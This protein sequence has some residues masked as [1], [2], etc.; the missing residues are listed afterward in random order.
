MPARPARLL[1]S[2]PALLTF[3]VLAVLPLQAQPAARTADEK[4]SDLVQLTKGHPA[5]AKSRTEVA[6]AKQA[7][8][9]HLQVLA[10]EAAKF[11]RDNPTH[12]Q[13]A[14][15]RRWEAKSRLTIA[16][17]D[18]GPPSAAVNALASEVRR[19][20][21]LPEAKRYEVAFLAEMAGEGGRGS[22]DRPA[23]FAAREQSARTLIAEFPGQS[24]GYG[25]LL[26]VAGRRPGAPAA[27][28]ARELT[29]STAPADIK[30][31]AQDLL[32]RQ[33]L[34]GQ[35]LATI[36]SGVLGAAKLLEPSL[37]KPLILYTW[38]PANPGSIGLAK[39]LAR[40]APADAVVIGIN[41]S[42]DVPAAKAAAAQLPG[43]QLYD[44]RG[45]DSPLVRRLRLTSAPLVCLVDR[46]GIIRS[47]DAQNDLAA[48]LARL[49]G[50]P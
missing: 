24:G 27:S 10:N 1:R 13:V 33:A 38:S 41:V 2:L 16:L 43:V 47:T 18:A 9:A 19:D 4:W 39:E 29:A 26:Q 28:L 25:L 49:E 46:V 37:G 42:R 20:S 35:T 15:A 14:E 48:Q 7:Q 31:A 34:T 21:R 5:A 50:K 45:F 40:L 22:K 23:W 32:D 36:T 30:T 6:T 3:S 17:L 44:G 8:Q 11:A 12:S